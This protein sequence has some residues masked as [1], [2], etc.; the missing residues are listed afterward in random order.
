MEEWVDVEEAVVPLEARLEE[1]IE[2][3]RFLGVEGRGWLVVRGDKVE[4]A[5]GRGGTT[6][7]RWRSVRLRRFCVTWFWGGGTLGCGW[8]W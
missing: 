5:R 2:S 7:M 1:R 8:G 6:G 3:A 4:G